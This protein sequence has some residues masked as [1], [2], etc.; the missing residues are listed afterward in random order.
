MPLAAADLEQYR[1][2][3]TGHCYRMLGS[4][5]DADDAVQDTLVRAWRSLDRFEGRSALG[6]WLYRIATNVCLNRLRTARRRPEK[7]ETELLQ[8]IADADEPEGRLMARLRL[9]GPDI[10]EAAVRSVGGAGG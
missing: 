3:L 1:P 4:V 2:A 5:V 6:S 8:R 7:P 10:S 9:G